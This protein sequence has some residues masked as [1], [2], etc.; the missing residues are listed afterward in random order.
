MRVSNPCAACEEGR[1]L[2]SR[3]KRA[4]APQAEGPVCGVKCTE[5]SKTVSVARDRGRLQGYGGCQTW[6]WSGQQ[7]TLAWMLRPKCGLC[8]EGDRELS[9]VLSR[10]VACSGHLLRMVTVTAG[11]RVACGAF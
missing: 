10:R 6:G 8:P 1:E 5:E 11:W 3:L 4:T 7:D 2:A 9:K